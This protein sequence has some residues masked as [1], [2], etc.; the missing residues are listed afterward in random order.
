MYGTS[1]INTAFAFDSYFES[2]LSVEDNGFVLWVQS[3]KT[4]L[5]LCVFYQ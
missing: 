4:A 1:M 2:E 3:L 5:V